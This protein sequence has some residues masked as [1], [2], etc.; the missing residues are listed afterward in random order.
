MKKWGSLSLSMVLAVS[1][2]SGCGSSSESGGTGEPSGNQDNVN[3]TGMPIVKEKIEL[4]FFTG[5][6][7]T[8]GSKF[9]E[10]LIWKTYA[11]MSN[12]DVNFNLVP[13]E[14]L[15]EKRNLALA[16]G[17]YPD[18]FYSAR[19]T[20]NELARFGAQGVFIPLNDL[21]DQYAPNF[22]KLMEQ[23]PDIRKGLTMPDG[24]I[25]S[26]PSFYD[27]D[28]LSMLIGAPLWINDEWLE[29]LNM[30]EPET[31]EEF[32]EYLKAVQTTDLNGN[33]QQDE[34]PYS[35]VG[36]T[37]LIDHL[38]GGWGLGTRGL[39]HKYVDVDPDS[40]E[41]RFTKALPEYKELLQF[42]NKLHQEK[43]LDPEIFTIDGGA[44]N[45]KGQ[46]GILGSTAVPNP[47]TVMSQKNYI[48]LG[49]L[50]GPGGDQLYS[51]IKV[52]MVHVGAFAITDKNENPEATIRWMDYFYGDDGAK[53]YFMGKEG[54]TYEKTADGEFKYVEEITNN[55]DGLTQD[56]AL[57]K[58][59]TW[60]GGS[61]PG[62]VRQDYF[63]GSE[64]L[65]SSMEAAA[66][67][68]PHALEEI[69]YNFNYTPEETEFMSSVGKDIHDYVT[70]MEAKF[71]NGSASFEQ[72]D[73]YVAT[74]QKMGLEEYMKTY[75]AAYDRYQEG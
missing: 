31:T 55:P 37:G 53:L 17:D 34:V 61:Y 21:I 33:G 38:K 56:Q 42:I 44:L 15:T 13:F 54:E 24:N 22:K 4:D 9:E 36:I 69:W 75:Q 2:L 7:A 27:P 12:V 57:A 8:N 3:A 63:K 65:S 28:L 43:L 72:W 74:L 16:G 46:S 40:G 49:A 73:Q 52:P 71:V 39:G 10:T 6:S 25:Y 59:F 70:E 19:V 35:A 30:K 60:L 47:E 66:K 26:L 58:Y 23:Y 29:K 1:L 67:A 14:T 18:V 41:L 11:E 50:K 20:S 64:T 32:Y 48:G 5:K 45:A 68:E 62:V 51:H